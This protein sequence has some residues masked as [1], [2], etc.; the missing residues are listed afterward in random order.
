MPQEID[1]L[2]ISYYCN[3][4][5][6]HNDDQDGPMPSLARNRGILAALSSDEWMKD[7]VDL[8][9]DG[10]LYDF[11]RFMSWVRYG[12]T[13]ECERY[14]PFTMTL[15]SG[16]YYLNLFH[17]HGFKVRVVN[18]A[19]RQ[20]LDYVRQQ[21]DPR[22]V[23][24]STTLLFDA[25]EQ[26]NVA[27]A[28]QQIRRTWADAVI[29]L[30]GLMLVSY[31][32]NLPRAVFR[33]LLRGYGA[34]VYVVTPQGERPILEIL[35]RKTLSSLLVEPRVPATYVVSNGEV[36]EPPPTVEQGLNM[37]DGSIRWNEL[38][39]TSHLYHTV[40]MRTARSC[41]FKCAFCEYPVNQGPLTL[42]PLDVVEKEL[43][44]LQQLGSVKSLIFTDDT[45]NVPLRR[46]KALLKILA[47]FDFEWYS[48]FRPQ[49]ADEET[50]RLMKAAN[51]RAVFAGLE[52][53]DDQI[54]RNM[55]KVAKADQ[56][57]RGIEQLKRQ[58]IRIHT[59]F[60]VGFPGETE[61]SARKIVPFLDELE[62]EFCTVCLW[63]YIPSTPIGR[64]SAEFGIEGIGVEWKHN[65]MDWREAQT[66]A[67]QIVDD[68]KYAVHNAVR[69][70][71]WTGFMLYANGFSVDDAR[72]AV[73]TFNRYLGRDCSPEEI[74]GSESYAALRSLL[75]RRPMPRPSSD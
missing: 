72:L 70:E 16:T 44:E 58:G 47:K 35:R 23:L 15:L 11:P 30:G 8:V 34:D 1:V 19:N 61:A 68:Q 13:A 42:M 55:N 71:A 21:Y 75:K 29:V 74:K 26:D 12:S 40:H 39:Q 60:I 69:G 53:V 56:Y 48:F 73:D 46:F 17:Q 7:E 22:F 67:R 5:R 14:D 33:N 59:N 51:C 28:V 24:L 64:R 31:E 4:D 52:S 25:A 3:I 37:E 2:F 65:T 45:F 6:W 50:A 49:Y 57:R 32:K 18:A 43:H 41:A 38:P 62:I 63:C 66:L 27:V 20:K 36:V 54:L 10:E 9:I